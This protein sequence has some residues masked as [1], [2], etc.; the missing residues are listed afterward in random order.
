MIKLIIFDLNGVCYTDEEEP[1]KK[2]LSE[3][4]GIDFETVSE[5]F[6]KFI[7]KAETVE[8]SGIE[9]WEKIKETL[10]I[11]GDTREMIREMYSVKK[12]IK[13][14]LETIKTLKKKYDVA[15]LTSLCKEHCEEFSRRFDWKKYFDFGIASYQIKTRKPNPK[16]YQAVMDHFGVKPEETVFVDDSEKNAK[17]AENICI[18]AIH[19]KDVSELK[20][21][22]RKNG[23]EI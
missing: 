2:K 22:L 12:E 17:G 19:L 3:R 8:I 23:V 21:L 6:D 16:A 11:Q 14:T 18:H 13:E 9:A 4:S 5:V 10:C 7:I 20:E 1:Y 15:F